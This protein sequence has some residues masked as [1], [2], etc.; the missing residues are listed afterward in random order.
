MSPYRAVFAFDSFI[1]LE[2]LNLTNK[3][4]TKLPPASLDY[5][6]FDIFP[7]GAE[8]ADFDSL[9]AVAEKVGYPTGEP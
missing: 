9:L 7:V 8:V 2:K 1:G 3:Q 6:S 4:S 5:T